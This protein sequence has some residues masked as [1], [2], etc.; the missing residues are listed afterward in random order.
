MPKNTLPIIQP[1]FDSR[2]MNLKYPLEGTRNGTL[3]RGFMIWHRPINGYS[4]RAVV[5]F[6]YNPSTVSA[7]FSVTDPS[8]GGILLFPNS[9]DNT[10][11]RV[12]LSQTVSWSI[13]YDRTYEIWGQYDSDGKPR[14]SAGPDFNNPAVVGVLADIFQMEQF[15]GMNVGYTSG[16]TASH[17]KVNDKTMA[18]RQGVIQLVPSYVHFGDQQNMNFYGYISEWDFTVTHWTQQMVPIR[19][20]IDISWTMLPPPLQPSKAPGAVG[21]GGTV[22]PGPR[23]AVI[24]DVAITTPVNSGK[25]GR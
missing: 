20:I 4:G 3:R 22:G 25:S 16:F 17:P 7:T 18:G 24:S 11:L 19:C 21:F 12:P 2:I 9:N 1:P 15:T 10:D 13:L 14:Q 5:K 8:V 23:P 6:L